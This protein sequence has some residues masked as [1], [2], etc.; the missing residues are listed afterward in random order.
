[1]LMVDKGY[2]NEVISDFMGISLKSLQHNT[3]PSYGWICKGEEHAIRANTGRKRVNVN[4]SR[5]CKWR[6]EMYTWTLSDLPWAL[7]ME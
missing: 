1:M 5:L 2:S 6:L 7:P 3:R 4:G